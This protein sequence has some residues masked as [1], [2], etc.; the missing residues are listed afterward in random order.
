[1]EQ[2]KTD[3]ICF[4]STIYCEKCFHYINFFSRFFN[5]MG[6]VF[7]FV[8]SDVKAKLDIL[9]EYSENEKTSS[10][11]VTIKTMMQYEKD[12]DLLDKKDYVSGSRT[13]LRLHRG[14]DFIR[15]FMRELGEL[16]STDKTCHVCQESYDKTLAQYHPWLIR[17][18]AKV[19]MYT[20]PNK[21]HLLK[22]VSIKL[23]SILLSYP[24]SLPHS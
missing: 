16:Q 12:A 9:I 13:L 10:S 2:L 18:G 6:T 7:G 15:V 20:L 11:F 17:K 1:M 24:S 19:A 23:F 22:R 5:L 8:S 14:L 21:E 3:L 4:D